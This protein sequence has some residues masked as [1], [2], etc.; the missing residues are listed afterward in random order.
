M[1]DLPKS[2]LAQLLA[3]YNTRKDTLTSDEQKLAARICFCT[4]CQYLWV[5]RLSQEPDRC[6]NCHRRGWNMPLVNAML[7][8]EPDTLTG[9]P[10]GRR[11]L[12]EAPNAKAE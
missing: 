7:N 8:R 11:E 6:P 9:H 5:R 4:L 3:A 12:P 1:F 2:I 10:I